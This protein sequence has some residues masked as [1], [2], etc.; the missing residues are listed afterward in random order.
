MLPPLIDSFSLSLSKLIIS[1]QKFIALQ[2]I[3]N[4]YIMKSCR[5]QV[6]CVHYTVKEKTDINN[7]SK[8]PFFVNRAM[9]MTL[10]RVDENTKPS[11]SPFPLLYMV[12]LIPMSQYQ[13]LLHHQFRVQESKILR[14]MILWHSRPQRNTKTTKPIAQT[15]C[16][17]TREQRH[18]SHRYTLSLSSL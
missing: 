10:E 17:S 16:T 8:Y 15:T 6:K 3:I 11:H 13:K 5:K 14:F 9:K 1:P 4:T 7:Y 18:D 12:V 2:C